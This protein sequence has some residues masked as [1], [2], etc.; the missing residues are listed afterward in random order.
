[1]LV[2]I[3]GVS[4]AKGY[5]IYFVD[6]DDYIALNTLNKL[7]KIA[8]DYELDILEFNG[9]RTKSRKLLS[10]NT[11]IIDS[12]NLK[13]LDGYEFISTRNFHDGVWVY[14]FNRVFLINSK[15]KFIEG[16]VMEDMIYTAEL[17][18][19]AKRIGFYPI[20]VYR[21]VINPNSIWTTMESQAHRK[22]IY[23]FI[24]MTVKYTALIEKSKSQYSYI[25]K[26][27][28][29]LFTIAK[30]LLRSDFK[31]SKI[32]HLIKYLSQHNSY[33]MKSY[34]GKNKYR[35][36]LTFIFNHKYLFF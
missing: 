12:N 23:D 28:S 14:F 13:I 19:M 30:R 17:I 8:F 16:K 36:Y 32:N 11:E 31:Y 7:L 22:S 10:S 6:S 3:I 15:V 33:P 35:R 27:Q 25:I 20:D 21:Y 9:L 18:S 4:L 24:F 34:K 1:M 5:Y 26:K 2:E 29:M